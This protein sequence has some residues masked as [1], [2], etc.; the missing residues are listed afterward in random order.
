MRERVSA[1]RIWTS[2]LPVLAAVGDD[3]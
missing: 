1:M 3:R 2:K